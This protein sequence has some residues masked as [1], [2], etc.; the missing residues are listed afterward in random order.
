MNIKNI[1]KNIIAKQG[2]ATEFDPI[3]DEEIDE[4]FGTAAGTGT[5]AQDYVIE[6]GTDGIWTYRKWASGIAECW[7]INTVT[8]VITTQW[9]SI[10][11]TTN[12][13]IG[14]DAYPTGLFMSAPDVWAHTDYV[15]AA[16]ILF[17]AS[18]GTATTAPKYGAIRGTAS[19]SSGLHVKYYLNAKGRW[20]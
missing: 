18:A 9:G 11:Q 7:G 6:H 14:G 10:Y 19:S 4:M 20:K 5:D 17:T 8:S 1:L 12:N 16:C 15:E 13:N 2:T 3:T